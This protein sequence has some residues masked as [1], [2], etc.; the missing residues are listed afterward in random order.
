[1]VLHNQYESEP[2]VLMVNSRNRGVFLVPEVCFLDKSYILSKI[3]QFQSR[4]GA[5]KHKT[6]PRLSWPKFLDV[7]HAGVLE[8]VYEVQRGLQFFHSTEEYHFQM[9]V[10]LSSPKMW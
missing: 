9:T 1:M 2:K 5:T 3:T 7:P 8:P 10:I 4:C 6:V